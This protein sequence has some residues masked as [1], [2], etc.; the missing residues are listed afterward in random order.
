M[1]Q[2]REDL[3]V[4]DVDRSFVAERLKS[5]V[6]EGR[7]TLAEYDE[8]LR[9]TYAAKTYGDLDKLIGD[10]PGV[11]PA[12][13]GGL[14]KAPPNA[15]TAA[16]GDVGAA[17]AGHPHDGRRNAAGTPEWRAVPGQSGWRAVPRWIAAVWGVWIFAVSINIMIWFL[18]SVSAGEPVYFWPMWVAGPWGAVLLATTI[19]GL[20]AGAPYRMDRSP[21]PRDARRAARAARRAVRR[22]RRGW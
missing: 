12:Q 22:T 20:L 1:T 4:A 6:D 5:A 15:G 14:A 16:T 13:H 10:L 21:G 19:T 7:L 11:T 18:V 17:P 8:R 3:R 2:R 9:D